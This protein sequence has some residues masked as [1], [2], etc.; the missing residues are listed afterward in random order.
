MRIARIV[1]DQ[2][3]R[4]DRSVPFDIDDA[5]NAVFVAKN[6][7]SMGY[8]TYEVTTAPGK[9]VRRLRPV[10]ER[11]PKMRSFAVR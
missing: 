7:P 5:G 11:R 4:P 10:R 9:A 6:V 3:L 1:C 8:A 2:R